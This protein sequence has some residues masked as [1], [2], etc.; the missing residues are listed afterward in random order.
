[1]L[2]RRRLTPGQ[3]QT[4]I[5]LSSLPIVLFPGTRSPLASSPWGSIPSSPLPVTVLA[6]IRALVRLSASIPVSTFSTIR[7]PMTMQ[8]LQPPTSMPSPPLCAAGDPGARGVSDG[9]TVV[10]TVRGGHAANPG[11]RGIS[12]PQAVVEAGDG[13]VEDPKSC[14]RV[15]LAAGRDDAISAAVAGER[16][17]SQDKAHA[18]GGDGDRRRGAGRF[19]RGLG[20]IR[21]SSRA[22]RYQ[23]SIAVKR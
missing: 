15:V 1:M 6:A 9:D 8:P 18:V 13:A 21:V 19:D 11:A 12:M 16:A 22:W 17:A 2:V 3:R 5:A 4:T 20:A 23:V 7:S 14:D 10:C